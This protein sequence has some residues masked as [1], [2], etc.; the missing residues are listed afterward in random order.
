[1]N[2]AELVSALRAEVGK[3]IVGQDEVVEQTL[4]ALLAGGHVMLEGVPGLGKTLL[5]RALAHSLS[6]SFSRIQFTP[7][8][9]PADVTGSLVFDQRD[10]SFHVKRGPVFANLVLADEV[11]R[12]PPKTQAALLE[13]MEEQQVTID[14]EPHALPQPF[15]VMATQNPIEYEGTYPLPEAQLDRFLLKVEVGYPDEA[16]ELALLDRYCEGFRPRSLTDAGLAP[17]ATAEQVSAAR[18]EVA[19]VTV[20][21]EVRSYI[22]RLVR[23][24]REWPSLRL[25][26][27]P[28]AAVALL[29]AAQAMAAMRG[30]DFAI[31]DDVQAVALPCLRHRVL[32]RPE[33]ELEGMR[34]DDAVRQV[35]ATVPVP[36]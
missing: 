35:L 22:A 6:L 1:L 25:G 10:A 7:D 30:R 14:G 21:P 5:V 18:R 34:P 31:P 28:R 23:T 12:T 27:S 36:R 29:T 15:M 32:L 9:M 11:N 4:L 20:S 26:A 3:A 19:A 8:Q 33:M 17:A 2:V 16:S 13:A 24:T